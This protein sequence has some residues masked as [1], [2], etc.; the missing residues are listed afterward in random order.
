M[1]SWLANFMSIL[2]GS[3]QARWRNFECG[4][5]FINYI[6]PDVRSFRAEGVLGET[7]QQLEVEV[8]ERIDMKFAGN[9]WPTFPT[10]VYTQPC[11]GPRCSPTKYSLLEYFTQAMRSMMEVSFIPFLQRRVA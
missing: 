9:I 6:S 10:Q 11:L 2:W 8:F 3:T 7:R 1:V 5:R 4:F